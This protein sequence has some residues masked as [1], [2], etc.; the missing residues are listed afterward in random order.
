MACCCWNFD[1]GLVVAA[2]LIMFWLFVVGIELQLL[3]LG[4]VFCCYCKLLQLLLLL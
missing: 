4:C 3:K 1:H 2:I